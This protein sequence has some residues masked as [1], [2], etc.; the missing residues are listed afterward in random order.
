[1][2]VTPRR[3]FGLVGLLSVALLAAAAS[4]AAAAGPAVPS[5]SWHACNSDQ[6]LAQCATVRV[7]LDYD[8]PSG[9]TTS[10]AL[11]RVPATDAN[12]AARSL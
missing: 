11:A 2:T 7:P 4:P 5:L 10:L 8:A 9:A 1:M 6:S 12:H 3:R